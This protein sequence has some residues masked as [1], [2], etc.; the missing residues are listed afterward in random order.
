[1]SLEIAP[2]L[3]RAGL[4]SPPVPVAQHT[5]LAAGFPSRAQN[6]TLEPWRRR[7]ASSAD[8]MPVLCTRPRSAWPGCG[9][10]QARLPHAF[11]A[12]A[13]TSGAQ[14]CARSLPRRAVAQLAWRVPQ[15]GVRSTCGA[16]AARA[17]WCGLISLN[18]AKSHRFPC[19]IKALRS[20]QRWYIGLHLVESIVTCLLRSAS[21]Y[22]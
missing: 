2:G 9:R 11:S 13:S 19:E 3:P 15:V 21:V 17:L 10:L 14:G 12:R 8:P 6:L 18:L 1:M 20:K 16:R 4:A 22:N 7:R 5:Y